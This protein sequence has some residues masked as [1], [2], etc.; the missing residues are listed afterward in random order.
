MST[1]AGKYTFADIGISLLGDFRVSEALIY[2]LGVGGIIY[3]Y[4]ERRLRLKAIERLANRQI[5]LE[6]RI[7]PGRS[8]S[9]LTPQGTTRP[10]DIP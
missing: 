2:I 5:E 9:G 3:G 8:S 1:Y 7:D 6:K 10:E 4:G